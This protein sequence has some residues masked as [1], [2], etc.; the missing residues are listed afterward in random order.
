MK[1]AFSKN[2]QLKSELRNLFKSQHDKISYWN[3][4][5]FIEH[6]LKIKLR[7]WEEDALEGRLDRLGMAFIEFNEFNEFSIEQGLDWGEKLL[8]LDLEDI[9]DRKLNLSYKDYEVTKLDFFMDCPTMLKSEKAALA[10]AEQ[11]FSGQKKNALWVDQDFGPK[12][13]DDFVGGKMAM[14]KT[15]KPFAPGYPDPQNTVWLHVQ[16]TMKGGKMVE[17]VDDGVASDDCI[18]GTLG[19]CWFIT[20]LSVLATRDEL[21]VGGRKGMDYDVDMI[22]DKDIASILDNG[23]YPPIFHKYRSKGIYVF[24][25]FKNFE[26]VY[27]LVDQRIPMKAKT[28][29]PVFGRCRGEHELW[30]PLIE[31][32][33][34]K[35]HGC[36]ENLM[37]G[38]LDEGVQELTGM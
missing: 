38:Y 33:Y 9:L 11:L 30:V 36:Y 2:P 12:N 8:S 10:M 3:L 24:R 21:L 31:K 34:A 26:W 14:Y 4:F 37:S 32:A 19:D 22:I 27:V 17:F 6:K 5:Q 7:N 20:A 23:V 29:K 13:R 15:G 1:D 18:Q 25:F 28:S 35:L 16:D